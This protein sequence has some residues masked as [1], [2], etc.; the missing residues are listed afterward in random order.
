[1]ALYLSFRNFSEG[2]ALDLSPTEINNTIKVKSG[3]NYLDLACN[4]NKNEG[5]VNLKT[6]NLSLKLER[7]E[8]AADETPFLCD[9]STDSRRPVVY[10]P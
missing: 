1:M 8:I 7:L 10:K 4:Q 9:V 2:R 5:I 6:Q 3:I